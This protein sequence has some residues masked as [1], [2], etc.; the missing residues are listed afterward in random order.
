MRFLT[1]TPFVL[2]NLLA[3]DDGGANG[4]A[5]G[6]G[7]PPAPNP[8]PPAPEQEPK[9]EGE[10]VEAKLTSATGII[11]KLFGRIGALTSQLASML[12]ERK[13]LEGQFEELA[14][15]FQTEKEAHVK[16]QGELSKANTTNAGLTTERDNANKNVER[17]EKLCGL[18]GIDI[19]AAVDVPAQGPSDEKT[20]AGKWEKYQALSKQEREG[21]VLAGTAMA[22]WR[23]NKA[24]LDKYAASKRAA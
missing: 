19:S 4:G 9:P 5:G 22:Y 23:E 15:N 8:T 12:S 7:N 21:A 14:G 3:E 18:K 11:S 20:P 13:K 17:L 1:S 16:T 2:C 6:G 10:T 24:D